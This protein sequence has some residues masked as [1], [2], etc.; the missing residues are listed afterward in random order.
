MSTPGA[1]ASGGQPQLDGDAVAVA[2]ARVVVEGEDVRLVASRPVYSGKARA[3]VDCGAATLQVAGQQ[4]TVPS[5]DPATYYTAQ[6]FGPDAATV[7]VFWNFAAS[8]YWAFKH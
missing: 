3:E 1:A 4:I 6:V 2:R 7:V 8:K 5:G